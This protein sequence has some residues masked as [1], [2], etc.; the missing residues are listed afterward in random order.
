M[1]NS[2]DGN[3]VEMDMSTSCD[4]L[5]VGS[6]SGGGIAAKVLSEKGKSVLLVEEG[7]LK[8]TKDFKMKEEEAYPQLYQESAARLTKDK[9]IKILQGRSVG[10]GT[11][12]NWTT[13]FRTPVRTLNWWNDRWDIKG[14]STS[15]MKP[16]FETI[17]KLVNISPWE[18]PPNEN[19]EV[20]SMGL[21]K[22]G[23][24]QGV[25]SRNVKD[26]HN[27]GYCGLGCPVGAKQSTLVTA[28]PEAMEKGGRLYF[29]SRCER[30]IFKNKKLIGALLVSRNG[31]NKI[32]VMC[33]K[34]ILAGGA[35]GTPAIL[36]RSLAPDPHCLTGKR[37]FV[38]PVCLSGAMMKN[39]V[40]PW[41]GAPQ[42]IYSDH[43]LDNRELDGAMGFK[44]EVPPIHPI[45]LSTVVDKH[46]PDHRF[47]M[48]NF[49]RFQAI[50]NLM[51]DGFHENSIGGEVYL[52][53]DGSPGLDYK[54]TD[55]VWKGIKEAWL[56]SAEVQFAAGA[57]KVWP[58][59]RDAPFY[60]NWGEAK[61]G[62]ENLSLEIL[63][64][65][66]VSAHV[67]GGCP[68]SDDESKGVV[69][70][71]GQHHQIENLYI[72]DGSVFPTSVGANPM[73]SIMAMSLKNAMKIQ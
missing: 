23:W 12:I 57:Q 3:R 56:A 37:T 36:K 67:M 8:E 64:A 25:I 6:G 60:K 49:P 32:K 38:H 27:L 50:L 71:D 13:S 58:I 31:K 73:E 20:L 52:K 54:I 22:L 47:I 7:P 14:C 41:Q 66:V 72:L 61:A 55:Y 2:F 17:E 15:E 19:N 63:K 34:I 44:M 39:E 48:K 9:G 68:M 69:N 53:A 65:K 45:I 35:I 33:E 28:I 30:L 43:F 51:R 10:G 26:C 21:Q 29:N 16:Y 59:H 62:I 46:G 11:T 70:S 4:V 1:K 5:I 18:V 24:S 40:E 42:V